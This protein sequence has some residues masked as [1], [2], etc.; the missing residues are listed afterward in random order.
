M[1]KRVFFSRRSFSAVVVGL[2]L[3]MLAGLRVF[4]L[5]RDFEQ[6]EAFY[7]LSQYQ[8]GLSRFEP[9]FR[10]L[11]L[12]TNALGWGFWE[13]LLLVAFLSVPLKAYV[14]AKVS[15][16][17][18]VPWLYYIPYFFLLFDMTAI[19]LGVASAILMLGIFAVSVRRHVFGA[20]LIV[21]SILFHYQMLVPVIAFTAVITAD[22]FTARYRKALSV[23]VLGA[24]VVAIYWTTRY[25]DLGEVGDVGKWAARYVDSTS[26]SGAA[27][28]QPSVILSML[29][30]WFGRN[31]MK[32]SVRLV[33][34][35]WFVGAFGVA[36]Y[37]A[38]SGIG[39]IVFR[40]ADGLFFFNLFWLG[41]A[42][43]N[44]PARE[45]LLMKLTLVLFGLFY[46]WLFYFDKVPYLRFAERWAI[47]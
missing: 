19:R 10:W 1:N 16:R 27:W 12:L 38:L 26:F 33:R 17:S 21:V 45:R 32:S 43:K 15:Q 7:S 13:F 24:G 34:S 3:A 14:I 4:G 40:L 39:V 42:A 41:Y 37:Y 47:A 31:A 29:L 22:Y 44:A 9:G 23:L 8:I 2:L 25:F 11:A 36:I 28:Y 5:D 18:V 35:S 46:S 30:L 6:Y 20:A